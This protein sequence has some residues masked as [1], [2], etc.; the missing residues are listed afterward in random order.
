MI[1]VLPE[2]IRPMLQ[3]RLPDWI[4]P[5]WWSDPDNLVEMAPQAEIGWFDLH[6]KPPALRSVQLARDLRWLNTSYSGVD[7]LPLADLE[8]RDVLLTCGSN[9]TATQVSE[10]AVMSILA[11][12]KDYAALV[13]AQ[14][15]HEWLSVPPG[16]R[17]LAGSRALIL[18]YGAIGRAIARALEGFGVEVSVVRSKAGDG[19]MGPDEWQDQLDSFDWVVLALPGTADTAGLLGAKEFAAMKRDAVL[20]NFARADIVDQRALIEALRERRVG[21]AI[22][23]TV[24]PEPLPEDHP[25]WSLENAHVTMHLSGIPT[26][27]SQQ[28]AADRFLRNCEHFRVGEK[29]EAQVDL[30]RGY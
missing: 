8:A 22:V 1:A 14:D 30:Q 10:F 23:D 9:L 25:F 11:F 20:V 16:I 29:L 12:A 7:W 26:P 17:D 28:R 13:R 19:A 2:H 21:G 24:D 27:A 4:E 3:D 15:A 5:I 6:L 18:G